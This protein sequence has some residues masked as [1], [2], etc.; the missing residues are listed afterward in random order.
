MKKKKNIYIIFKHLLFQ[1]N[2]DNYFKLHLHLRQH[3]NVFYCHRNNTAANSLAKVKGHRKLQK[4]N[5]Q[6]SY[7]TFLYK[8][9]KK[10]AYEKHEAQI[11]KNVRIM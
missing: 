3:L 8:Q 4:I 5:F 7:Y 11:P 1:L 10:H 6:C 9:Y 2:I